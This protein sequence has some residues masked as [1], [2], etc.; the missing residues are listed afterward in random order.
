MPGNAEHGRRGAFWGER[1]KNVLVEGKGYYL[2]LSR[3]IDLNMVRAGG[4]RRP[5]DWPWGGYRAYAYGEKNDLINVH[6]Y[7]LEQSLTKDIEECR[8]WYRQFVEAQLTTTAR[9][10]R[11]SDGP[12]FGSEA[13]IQEQRAKT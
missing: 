5:E 10:P 11:I 7:F 1:F 3:Y 8:A 12:F 13:F 4:G 2:E 9:D 6:P